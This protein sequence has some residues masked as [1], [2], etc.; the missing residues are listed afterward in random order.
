MKASIQS[1]QGTTRLLFDSVEGISNAVEQMHETI[2]RHPL[3]WSSNP[4]AP[5]QAHGIIASTVYSGIRRANGLVRQG[6]DFAFSIRA[7]DIGSS[8]QSNAEIKTVA[9]LNGAFGDYLEDTGNP[10]ATRMRLMLSGSPLEFN[11]SGLDAVRS[12]TSPHLVVFVHGLCLSEHSWAQEG[13]PDIAERL[14]SESDSTVLFLRYNTGRHI[15]TNGQQFAQLL[16]SLCDAWP[17]PVKSLSLIGH[18]M[19]GLVIRSASWYAEQEN[20]AWLNNLQRVVCLGTPH[21]GSPMAKAGHLLNVAM[22]KST[23]T[24]PLAFGK[25]RS[26]GIKDLRYGDLLDEDW[27]EHHPDH[28]RTDTRRTVPLIKGVEYYFA[29][30]TIGRDQNDLVGHVLG[31]LLVRLDSAVGAHKDDLRRLDIKLE[32]CRVFHQKTH[33]DLLTDE[34]VHQQIIDWCK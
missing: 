14:Q 7:P 21:L 11:D 29:A 30:A 25:R 20:A 27:Q 4:S 22:E 17:V 24:A 8:D 23:Y 2:A 18:S 31:D 33:L 6:T 12:Q 10:L 34:M 26:A 1:V 13:V 9:A 16:H 5:T 32:N 28:P 15:S 19:G 3:P